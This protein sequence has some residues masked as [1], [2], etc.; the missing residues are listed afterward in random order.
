MIFK[1]DKYS[2]LFKVFEN[3]SKEE[4]SLGEA[5]KSIKATNP[6]AHKV[7]ARHLYTDTMVPRIGNSFAYKDFLTRHGNSGIH[8]SLDANSFGSINKEHGFEKGNEAIKKLF[9]TISDISRKYGMKAFRVGGDEGRLHAPTP[10]RAN[11]FLK[12]LKSS[13]ETSPLLSGTNHRISVAVGVGY[14]PEHAEQSL[15]RAKDK[16]G[17]LISGK[18]VKEFK[19]GEEPTVSHSALEETPPAHWKPSNH[20]HK[21][22]QMIEPVTNPA[23][24]LANPL[25]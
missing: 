20:V 1:D 10:E 17:P 8:L 16:L 11:G 3:L 22:S 2:D 14:T 6:K 4:P 19:P 25:K 15:I 13:L 21:D 9:N 18:R 5:L 24:K 23:L 12:E 7:L